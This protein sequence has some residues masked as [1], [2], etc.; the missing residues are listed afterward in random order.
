[1]LQLGSHDTVALFRLN[2]LHQERVRVTKSYP[3]PYIP[4]Q[5]REILT[6]P[7]VLKVGVSVDND[8][9]RLKKDFD[10]DVWRIMLCC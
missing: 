2:M 3:P 10:V 8:V 5:V 7:K 1:M 9:N 4:R 6:N